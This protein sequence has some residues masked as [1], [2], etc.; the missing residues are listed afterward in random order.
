MN[1]T[2][3]VIGALVIGAGVVGHEYRVIEARSA[4]P[5]SL[6]RTTPSVSD[7]TALPRTQSDEGV[8]LVDVYGNEV[9]DAVGDYRVDGTGDLYETHS[10][11]TEITRLGSPGA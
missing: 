9:E 2:R 8:P 6:E 7:T 11:D 1:F 4:P 5:T 3:V 10:P